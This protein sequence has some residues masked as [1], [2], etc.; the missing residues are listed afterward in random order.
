MK[1]KIT[2]WAAYLLTLVLRLTYRYE[3]LF[4]KE[5]LYSDK[6]FCFAIWHEQLFGMIVAMR[7]IPF[8]TMA[9]KN[10]DGSIIAFVI[11]RLGFYTS[12]GSSNKGGRQGMLELAEIM[13][14]KFCH[15]AMAVDGPRGPRRKSKSGVFAL[16]D[17]ASTQV[18]GISVLPIRYWEFR[19]WDKFKLP[20]PFSKIYVQISDPIPKIEGTFLEKRNTLDQILQATEQEIFDYLKK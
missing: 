6:K 14:S 4:D 18:I 5:I 19:S 1:L 7:G 9:S 13:N 11:E 16:A 10:K 3:F 8:A 20:K 12:R 15:S 2:R 17:K